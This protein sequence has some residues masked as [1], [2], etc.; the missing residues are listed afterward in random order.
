M[1][2]KLILPLVLLTLLLV[3]S[4]VLAEGDQ[5]QVKTRAEI[6]AYK[7]ANKKT[8][9]EI[10]AYKEA[11]KKT[12]EEI[13]AYKAANK[14]SPEEIEAERARL[15]EEKGEMLGELEQKREELRT[16]SQSKLTELKQKV[17]NRVYGNIEKQLASRYEL[18]LKSQEK[19]EDRISD[20][21]QE[22]LDT[23]PASAKLA[24]TEAYKTAYQ[25]ALVKL[26]A[27][28]EAIYESDSPFKEVSGLR[29]A[30]KEVNDTLK[31]I[32]QL[33]IDAVKILVSLN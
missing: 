5:V 21:T 25:A 13:A 20:L 15:R 9:E 2:H 33:Q 19:I 4:P 32:R 27:Q 18:L 24:E 8:P 12:P 11:N 28:V 31:N 26:S 7:A 22:G 3:S 6:E 29:A 14:K 10:A 17:V 23:S 1:K 30:A 16:Q